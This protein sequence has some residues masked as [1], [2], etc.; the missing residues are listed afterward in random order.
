MK[1]GTVILLCGLPGAGKTTLA[2]KLAQELSAIVMSPDQELYDR[3]ISFFDEKA[4]TAI[5][6]EQWQQALKLAQKGATVV[7]E[8][9]FWGRSERDALR[10]E[11]HA[12]GLRIELRVLDVPFEE[13]WQRVDARNNKE[14][15]KD[16]VLS[17]E[18][19]ERDVAAFQMPSEEEFKLFDSPQTRKA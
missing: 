2:R 14:D 16:A 19:L 18:R 6:A 5:E 15:D 11:A 12:L 10:T 4:R 3:G 9:G 8:N 13:L 7:L 1:Q 17:R